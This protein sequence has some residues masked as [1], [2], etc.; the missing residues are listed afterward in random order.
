MF[1]FSGFPPLRLFDSPEGT[2]LLQTVS[3][4]IRI[5]AGQ[6]VLAARRS[7]SQ[8]DASFIGS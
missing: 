2:V 1:Q 3:Y 5:S 8:L 4:L 7:L 6:S